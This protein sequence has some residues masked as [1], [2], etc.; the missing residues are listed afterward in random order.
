MYLQ[1]ELRLQTFNVNV[2]KGTSEFKTQMAAHV[3]GMQ[4]ILG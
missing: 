1:R 4:G 3:C 2:G